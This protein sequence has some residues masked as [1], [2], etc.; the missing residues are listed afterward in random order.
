ML[1]RVINGVNKFK[2]PVAKA[3]SSY[4]KVLVELF[5]EGSAPFI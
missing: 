3:G 1:E 4:S 5:Y 2:L